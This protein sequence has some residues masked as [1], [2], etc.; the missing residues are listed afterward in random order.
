MPAS[1]DA[2]FI[3]VPF[4]RRYKKLFDA[5]VF[6]VHDC[7]FLARCAREQDDG[8][9]VRLEKLYGIIADC[10]FGIHDLSRTTL[11]VGSRL[12]RFNMPLELGI[13][14]G[15]KRF[16]G[17]EHS[18]KSCLILDRDPYRYQIFCSDIAGQD[19]R[20]HRNQVGD[21]ISAVRDWLRA[22]RPA[23]VGMPGPKRM[24]DRYVEFRLALPSICR[25]ARLDPRD[26]AFLDYRTLVVGW[27]DEQQ[28]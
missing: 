9:Q 22:A 26:L 11:D 16:G 10:R 24:M 19:I 13:F 21:A 18:R 1:S 5:L 15:A 3:N 17:G 25:E 20:A 8:S 27:L 12:P 2:V 7:G 28:Q 14:L 6:S 4:D 23:S